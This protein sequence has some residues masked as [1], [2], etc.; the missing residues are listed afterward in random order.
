MINQTTN[1]DITFI[2]L[3]VFVSNDDN[4][5]YVKELRNICITI[6]RKFYWGSKY[7]PMLGLLRKS[8]RNLQ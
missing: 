8:K 6:C 4:S 7:I 3:M 1:I 5:S 2:I